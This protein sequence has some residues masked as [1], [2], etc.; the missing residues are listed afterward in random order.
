MYQPPNKIFLELFT[1]LHQS[2]IWADGKII[3]DAIPLAAP[4]EILTKYR[5]EKNKEGFDLETFFRQNFFSNP[6]FSRDFKTNT[7][8]SVTEHIEILWDILK[9]EADEKMV[10]S[11]LIPLPHPYIVPGGRF[12]EIYYWDS[13]FTMLGLQVSGKLDLI[14]NMIDNFSHLIDTLGFIPNGNRTYFLGRSQPPFYA[15]MV[16]LL[17]EEKGRDI[18]VKYLPYLKKE[19]NF[20]MDGQDTLE[21]VGDAKAHVVRVEGGILNRYYDQHQGPRVEMYQTDLN[22]A[23][24]AKQPT[25]KLYANLRAACESGWDFSSRWLRNEYRLSSVYASEIIPVDLNCLL[26]YLELLIAKAHAHL[27]E[28]DIFEQ[29]YV[30]AMKRRILIKRLMWNPNTGFF[31]DY[32]FVKKTTT[33]ALTLAGLYPLFIK[34]AEADQAKLCAHRITK[35]FLKPGGLVTTPIQSGQQWDAPNGWAPLQWIGYQAFKNYGFHD[36]CD[37]IKNNWCKLNVD[38]YHQTGQLLEKYNVEDT[39]LMSGG[40]EYEVQGGFG[41]TNGVLLKMLSE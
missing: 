34:I 8:H 29:W 9:R 19:Y 11:S 4:K 37:Q 12:N 3:S 21:N 15:L 35:D 32:D 13:Y 31:H 30:L 40:G 27:K 17:A 33:P 1:D 10:G 38:V 14:E 7:A 39:S 20:W 6:N 28:V 18:W 25:E 36:V 16:D 41:W 26:L 23:Q 22:E 5:E 2:G 24:Q